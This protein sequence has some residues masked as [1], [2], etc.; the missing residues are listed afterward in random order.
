[1]NEQELGR[2]V[3][4]L[5]EAGLDDIPPRPRYLLEQARTAALTHA[6]DRVLP[7]GTAQGNALAAGLGRRVL[8]PALAL[9]VLLAGVLYWQQAQRVHQPSYADNA[10]V[11]TQVLTEELPVTAYLDRGFEIWLYHETPAAQQR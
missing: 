7:L 5:L 9:V 4:Q 1:V 2:K 3:A 6:R 8:A 11:D 10:D